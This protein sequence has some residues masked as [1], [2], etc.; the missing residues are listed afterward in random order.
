MNERDPYPKPASAREAAKAL[1]RSAINRG[2]TPEQVSDGGYG[3]Y[4]PDYN[5]GVGRLFG[6]NPP[7]PIPPDAIGV[8]GF[9]PLHRGAVFPIGELWEEVVAD[10]ATTLR[11]TTLFD[12]EP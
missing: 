10:T 11:Q 2:L 1:I 12:R 9:D 4:R 8:I 5:A 3:L 6:A 7:R